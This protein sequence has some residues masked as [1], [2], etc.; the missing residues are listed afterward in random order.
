MSEKDGKTE[1]PTAKRLSDA[2]KKGEL[3]K[4]QELISAISFAVITFVFV[5]FWRFTTNQALNL[6]HQF[7][8]T[9]L[10]VKSFE[11]NIMPL[12][13]KLMIEFIIMVAPFLL[14]GFMAALLASFTQV[15]F[16]FVPTA[17]KFDFK[18]LN[19]ISGFKNIFSSQAIFGL[20]KNIVKL[21]IIFYLV[22]LETKKLLMNY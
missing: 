13:L 2:R 16:L 6:M 14:I 4:S 19:P 21:V 12:A 17:I 3:A 15:G 8:S 10:S 18:K 5:P 7:Y 1:K 11:Q 20:L 9:Q 22:I